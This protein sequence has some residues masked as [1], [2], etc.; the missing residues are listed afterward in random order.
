MPAKRRLVGLGAQK[1]PVLVPG[2]E[3]APA[4]AAA[5]L[6]AFVASVAAA[7]SSAARK[8]F[9]VAS[10]GHSRAVGTEREAAKEQAE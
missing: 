10:H 9:G 3:G 4:I 5:A 7:A 6:A 1:Q 8:A 2:G